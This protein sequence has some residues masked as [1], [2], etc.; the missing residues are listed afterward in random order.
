MITQEHLKELFLYDSNSGEFYNRFSR[1]RAKAGNMA[2]SYTCGYW[3]LTVGYKRIYAHQAA[4]LYVHGVYVEEID[5]WDGNGLNNAIA[6]L[7]D[8]TR[9]QNNFNSE[10]DTGTSGLRGAYLDSRVQRWYSKIQISGQV[11]WLGHFDTAMEAHL[12]FMAAVE[13]YHGEY[14]YHNRPQN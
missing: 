10:R 14:A 8:V 13:Q 7:R 2:G 9:S 4:W 5:H 6:N 12:A 11:K 3:R 1:G